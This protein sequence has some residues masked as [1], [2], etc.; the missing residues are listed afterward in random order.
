M[1]VEKTLH[2]DV[3]RLNLVLLYKFVL[4][5]SKAGKTVAEGPTTYPSSLK[6]NGGTVHFFESIM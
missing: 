5:T 1:L 2:F 3:T 4:K 6:K